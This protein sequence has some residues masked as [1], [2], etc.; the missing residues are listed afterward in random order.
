MSNSH[1]RKG[2]YIKFRE[3]GVFMKHYFGK[4]DNDRL[5]NFEIVI[6]PGYQ[7]SPH[8]HEET[9]E[10]FYVVSG[11]GELWH[12]GNWKP[13]EKGDAFTAPMK[14]EHGL[15]NQ[16]P[17]KCLSCCQPSARLYGRGET[18]G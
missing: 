1:V 13:V 11:K 6:L 16:T 14:V 12:E 18:F 8:I 3:D 7:I 5:N 15:R 17:M 10:F 4:A 2:E 9:S